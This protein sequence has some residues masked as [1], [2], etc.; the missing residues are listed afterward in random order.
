[1]PNEQEERHIVEQQQSQGIINSQHVEEREIYIGSRKS[2]AQREAMEDLYMCSMQDVKEGC[3]I[4]VLVVEDPLGYPLWISKVIKVINENEDITVVDVHWYATSTHP[5]NGVYKPEMVVE[6]RIGRK[7]K[8]KGTNIN[9]RRTD[10]LKLEDVDILVYDFNLTKRGTLRLQTINI[11][12][13][14]LPEQL[15]LKWDSAEYRRR[16]TRILNSDMVG[17]HVDSD[18]AP[19][20][21]RE[22]Y[23]SSS[24]ASNHSSK[25]VYFDGVPE[26][27][28]DFE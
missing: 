10:V 9:R 6:K 28:A 16:S 14:L 5:F 4:A 12:K 21:E 1:M 13:K 25:D 20:D 22:E 2:H 3:M 18:G 15:L 19:V 17:M 24:S 8:R 11:L 23:G 26:P 7:R 27:M